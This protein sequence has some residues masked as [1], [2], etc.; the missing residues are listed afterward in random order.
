[1]TEFTSY[2]V[3]KIKTVGGAYISPDGKNIAYTLSVQRNPFEEEN[4]KAWTELHVVSADGESHPYVFGEVDVSDV[5]WTPDGKAISF[6]DKRGDDEERSLYSIPLDGGEA[7]KIFEHETDITSYSWS[8]DG[9]KVAFLAKKDKSEEEENLEE[10]GFNQEI[11]EED[12]RP[13]QVWI[14]DTEAEVA[15]PRLIDLSGSA[16]EL[17][18]GPKGE[19]LALALAPTSLIDDH[20]MFRRIRIVD[21]ESGE[22]TTKIDNPGKL[23]DVRWSP[24]GKSLAFVSGVDINDPSAGRIMVADVQ[25]GEFENLL[26]GFEGH[27]DHVE[28]T[29]KNTIAYIASE[30]VWTTFNTISKDGENQKKLI[31]KE[32]P[33]LN[34]FSLSKDGKVAA[35]DAESPKHPDEVFRYEFGRNLERLTDSNPWLKNKKLAEQE[36]VTWEAR[37]GLE[38]QGVLIK[39]LDYDEN[40]RYPLILAVHGGPESHDS[41]EWLTSYSDPG[42]VG[43]AQ[44]FAVFYPNY[45]GSTGRGVE[46]LKSSQ[47]NPA[48]KEFDDLVDAVDHFVEIGLADKDRVGITGGSYGGYA[49]AWGATYYSDRFAASVMFVGISDKISKTGTSDIPQELY[50]VHDSTWPWEDWMHFLKSSPI[51]YVEQAKTP[52]LIMHGEDDT[53]VN[54]GQ[55]MEL[56]RFLKVRNQAPVRLVFYK[57]EGHGNRK[58]ASK[59]DYSLRLMRWM[60]YYLKGDGGDPPE[61]PVAYQEDML[62]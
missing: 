56:Y 50:L 20:Y 17:H 4:G 46:F 10:Q 58:A 59:L 47:N 15:D 18:W 29:D 23:G 37:D 62:D 57:D 26:P 8:P 7:R 21:V 33:I 6:V 12:W 35:F 34:G 22:V 43:A 11:Y 44:G 36:V 39:P 2:D 3:A 45:R 25:S 28:W 13:V 5:A 16:S 40:K 54:P 9:K 24:D 53:R 61:Y 48:G 31:K 1:M 42:Q 27:V 55:S 60:N 49:S 38:L 30:S 19:R 41:N 14:Y 51:H 32:G 52:I